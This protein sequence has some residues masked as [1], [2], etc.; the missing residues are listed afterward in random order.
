MFIF[1]SI[2]SGSEFWS[3]KPDFNYCLLS[4]AML[5]G[6]NTSVI[7]VISKLGKFSPFYL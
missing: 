2:S 1:S 4:L 7:S 6:T 5:Q 3:R